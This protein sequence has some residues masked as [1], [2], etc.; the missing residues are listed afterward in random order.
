MLLSD[1]YVEG[2]RRC[3]RP[4]VVL[5]GRRDR[6]RLIVVLWHHRGPYR[7]TVT[8]KGVVE[9]IVPQLSLGTA[10]CTIVS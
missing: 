2:G 3:Y 8:L 1:S 4:T 10:V 6:D 9:T 5:Q 7:P